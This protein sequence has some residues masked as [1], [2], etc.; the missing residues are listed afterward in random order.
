MTAHP[1][2]DASEQRI[3]EFLERC[4]DAWRDRGVV[5]DNEEGRYALTVALT[6]RKIALHIREGRHREVP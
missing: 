3:V 1:P 6:Y 4:G 2:L 5:K